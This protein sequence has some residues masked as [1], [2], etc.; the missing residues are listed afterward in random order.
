L[1]DKRPG[2]RDI[3]DLKARLGLKKGKKKPKGGVPAPGAALPA[4]PG[5][6][7]PAPTASTDPFGAMNVAAAQR[8]AQAAA[9]GPEIIVVEKGEAVESVDNKSKALHY[10]KV[11]GAVIVPVV[12][13]IAIG[14]I[15]SSAKT[16]NRTI[17]DAG[18]IQKDVTVI[19]KSMVPLQYAFLDARKKGFRPD[20]KEL[21]EALGSVQLVEPNNTVV[22]KSWLYEL[23]TTLVGDVL[24]FYAQSALLA[25]DLQTHLT[26]TK[27][28]KKALL[29]EAVENLKKARPKDTENFVQYSSYRFGAYVEIPTQ[30]D[31]NDPN[32]KK[33]PGIRVVE[34]SQPVCQDGKP[35]A[36]GECSGP[37][38]GFRY[39]L[40]PTGK[41]GLK[42]LFPMKPGLETAEVDKL[43]LIQPTGVFEA[44]I[45]NNQPSVAEIYYKQRVEA[46][47][48]K[49]DEIIDLATYIENK[50]K[51]KSAEAHK[52]T[53]F[54]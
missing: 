48:N 21:T 53:F 28:I 12:V 17:V 19:R 39:R 36:T 37:L 3:S 47:A 45:K 38:K 15:S 52:F 6:E 46:L 29:S 18:K 30:Q 11:A 32:S 13:G 7:P 44:L 4:P 40:D 42:E 8:A 22:Y 1:S 2:A 24:S 49:T 51:A 16:Y 26:L 33:M 25:S 35:S 50:L 20:D 31:L 9:R 23:D 14:Q 43:M 10:L 5:A 27:G 41:W 34:I 54:L